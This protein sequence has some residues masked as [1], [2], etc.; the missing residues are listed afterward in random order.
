MKFLFVGDVHNKKFIFDDVK[1]LDTKYNFDRIIF[2]G[3]Y[4]DDWNT[5]NHNS[6]EILNIVFSLKDSDRAKYTFLLGNHE[7]S[8]LDPLYKCSG[9]RYNLEDVMKN[10]LIE[11]INDFDLF[12]SVLCGENNYIC[13]HAGLNN[14]FINKF[15]DGENFISKLELM[16]KNKLNY[17]DIISKCSYLRG[18]IDEFSSFL[19]CDL[20]E[21]EYFRLQQQY[22]PYQIVGHTPVNKIRTISSDYINNIYFNDTHSTNSNGD[23]IGDNSYLI[24]NDTC[25][26]VIK[27]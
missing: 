11:H 23:F 9:H 6:L 19:W 13:T 14:G 5:D 22:A 17:L 25:F 3:D 15:L 26:T 12:T 4:V 8:Y 24:W 2:L 16:N 18:G 21:H 20:R 1:K 27:V 10:Q 7:L